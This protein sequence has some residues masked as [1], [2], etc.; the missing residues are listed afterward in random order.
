MIKEKLE[1]LKNKELSAA[2]NIRH[3]LNVIEEK[4]DLNAVLA[5]NENA[6]KDAEAVDRKLKSGK[7]GKL[8]GLGILIKA[9]ISVLD[10]PISCASK[11]LEDY[12]GTFDADAVKKIRAEDGII[13]GI[14]N[15]DEFACGNSGESSAFGPTL[16]PA[17]PDRIPGGSSSGSAAAV[18]AGMCDIA[19]G[20]D[21]GGSI[22]NPA[23]H[24][25][26]VGVKP[27]YGRVSRFGLVDLSMSL[28][29]IGP[30]SPDVHGAALMTEV[31]AGSSKY[32]A[33][34]KNEPVPRYTT[35]KG[36]VRVG[37]S[38]NFEELCEDN[39]LYELVKQ[40]AEKLGS[41]K[42]VALSHLNLAVQTYY[43]IVYVEFF[44]GTRKFD[45]RRY[46]KKIEESCGVEVMR[47]IMG[48]REISKAEYEGTY[49]RKA[50]AVRRLIEK[51]FEKAFKDVDVIL[52]PVTPTLPRKIGGHIT[53]DPKV[54]YAEDA[55]TTPA[56]LAGVCA[57]VVPLGTIDNIPVGIQVIAPAFREEYLFSAMKKLET[58]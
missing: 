19:L 6:I 13:L 17:A 14:A 11:T 12:R 56:N 36:D 9:N 57:G 46:G 25:G 5:V 30:L 49:Y 34:T 47:R 54:I 15:M 41:V 58:Q 32:D 35:S 2:D 7:A 16:N 8:A 1:R 18:A 37:M 53:M 27:S 29:Q 10:L 40:A 24:C 52:A 23:S 33:T 31:I 39:R 4:K 45:G 43:P 51:E 48:G 22:R 26:V 3:F 20:S 55:L 21:T 28:D 50:L 38:K 44:S 42:N